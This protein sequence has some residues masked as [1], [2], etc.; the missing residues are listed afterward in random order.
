MDTQVD[1]LVAF[2]DKGFNAGTGHVNVEAGDEFIAGSQ[3][4]SVETMG[5][6]DCSRAPLACCV[7]TEDLGYDDFS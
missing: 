2:L 3:L 6:T 4:K 5:C 7:P 1:D